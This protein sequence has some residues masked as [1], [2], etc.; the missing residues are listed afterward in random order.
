MEGAVRHASVPCMEKDNVLTN[1]EF[2]RL[3]EQLFG[4]LV[5][6]YGFTHE[7]G[8]SDEYLVC[9]RYLNGGIEVAI[10]WEKDPRDDFVAASIN[11]TGLGWIMDLVAPEYLPSCNASRHSLRD[12]EISAILTKYALFLRDHGRVLLIGDLRILDD[13][14][15]LRA[16]PICLEQFELSTWRIFFPKRPRAGDVFVME[17]QSGG[18]IFGR[19]V[20]TD[21]CVGDVDRLLLLY[22]YRTRSQSLDNVPELRRDDLL[23]PPVLAGDNMFADGYAKVIA[24]SRLRKDHILPVHCFQDSRGVFHDEYN[25]I[26]PERV[27]PCGVYGV[28]CNPRR[29]CEALS[30]M[31][32]QDDE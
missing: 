5:D 21:A 15:K 8:A 11:G 17:R 20:R 22:I 2:L 9:L 28:Q 32:P 27:A 12:S 31:L 14:A 25:H 24:R 23:L 7:R 3:S 26:L 10:R 30:L 29:I 16:R 18:F 13:V 19:V 6:E 4:F 1:E